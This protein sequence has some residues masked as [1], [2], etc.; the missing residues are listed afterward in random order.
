MRMRLVQKLRTYSTLIKKVFQSRSFYASAVFWGLTSSFLFFFMQASLW[1]AL[2]QDGQRDGIGFSEVITFLV[3]RSIA[4]P[5]SGS[6]I[7]W[8][9]SR[10]FKSGDIA[11]M[12]IRPLEI[13]EQ[14]YCEEL[15]AGVFRFLVEGVPLALCAILVYGIAPPASPLIGIASALSLVVGAIIGNQLNYLIAQFV[16]WFKSDYYTKFLSGALVLVFGGTMVPIWFYPEWLRQMC[17]V[18][19]YQLIFFRPVEAYLGREE[20]VLA[21]LALGVAWVIALLV[22]NRL[23]WRAAR[24]VVV[25]QGG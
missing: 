22:A 9:I 25:I 2:L 10:P 18:L 5:F 4:A 3:V 23:L 13:R 6:R 20:S 21:T 8:L 19:P 17:R 15:G 11:T 1:T 16:F 14:V 12:F 24:R 7:S